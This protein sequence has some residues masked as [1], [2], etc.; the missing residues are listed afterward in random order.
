MRQGCQGARPRVKVAFG[1][2][3]KA[4]ARRRALWERPV[5]C[6]GY[7]VWHPLPRS[8]LLSCGRGSLRP[9]G[10]RSQSLC[11]HGAGLKC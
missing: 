3:V 10:L 7:P 1:F 5:P 2:S 4:S 6:Q 11:L 9:W 8:L